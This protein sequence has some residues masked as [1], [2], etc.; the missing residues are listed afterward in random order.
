MFVLTFNIF[1]SM[2]H[3]INMFVKMT[4][5]LRTCSFGC[6]DFIPAGGAILDL[7][8]RSSPWRHAYACLRPKQSH[9]PCHN[10][11]NHYLYFLSSLISVLQTESKR[12]EES[13]QGITDHYFI[14]LANMTSLK[15]LRVNVSLDFDG[16]GFSFV[17]RLDAVRAVAT[18]LVDL[19]QLSHL[20]LNLSVLVYDKQACAAM[21]VECFSSL[22]GGCPALQT[23]QFG[24]DP[25]WGENALE[26]LV[27]VFCNIPSL[28][29]MQLMMRGGWIRR[30]RNFP[31]QN[32]SFDGVAVQTDL[33]AVCTAADVSISFVNEW[34]AEN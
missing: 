11:A 26:A 23:V 4:N 5:I 13:D 14:S 16:D 17:P 31:Y 27:K 7:T 22:P 25:D 1:V 32:L 9:W 29:H 34:P 20:R 21:I 19:P 10:G 33:T 30:K 28:K 18:S 24:I 2:L 8:G 12:A 6:S 3:K 15:S